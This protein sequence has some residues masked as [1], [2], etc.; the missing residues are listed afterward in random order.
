MRSENRSN[1]LLVELLIVIMFFMLA[2]S[3][4]VQVF[5]KA[6][7]MSARAEEIAAALWDAQNVAD[8]LYASE[9]EEETLRALGFTAEGSLWRRENGYAMEVSL[10]EESGEAGVMSRAEVRVVSGGDTLL[11]LPVTRWKEAAAQ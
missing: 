11:T 6:R 1:A 3:V 7:S 9:D 8:Q 10:G 2:A 5:G 4:L